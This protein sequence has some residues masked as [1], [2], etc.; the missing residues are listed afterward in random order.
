MDAPAASDP[1]QPSDKFDAP[2]RI[3]LRELKKNEA[4][5]T[6]RVL[7]KCSSKISDEMKTALEKT[8][9]KIGTIAGNICTTSGNIHVIEHLQALQFVQRV[10]LSQQQQYF[11]P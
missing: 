8:G 9:L 11:H 10:S 3:K 1:F 2:L 6:L 4:K 7:V 5:E